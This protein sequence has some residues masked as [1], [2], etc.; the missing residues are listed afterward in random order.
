MP[1]DNPVPDEFVLLP[2]GALANTLRDFNVDIDV[3]DFIRQVNAEL[4]N[5]DPSSSTQQSQE[6]AK[7]IRKD[8]QVVFARLSL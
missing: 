3:H 7:A 4:S 5:T 2:V 1:I 8:E 6:H